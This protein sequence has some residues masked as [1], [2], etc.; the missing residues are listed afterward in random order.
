M[1]YSWYEIHNHLSRT[2]AS[3][4]F[5]R[6]FTDLRR[7]SHGVLERY[8]DPADVLSALHGGAI[9]PEEKNQLLVVLVEAAQSEVSAHARSGL[10]LTLLALWP[11]LDAVL[12]RLRARRLGD[13]EE[14]ASEVLARATEAIHSLDFG[15]VNRIAGTIVRNVERDII[16]AHRRETE[17]ASQ[18]VELNPDAVA[19]C[20]MMSV[21]QQHEGLLY[22]DLRRLIGCDADLVMRIA[23]GGSSQSEAAAELGHSEA[24]ARKRWQRAKMK[25]CADLQRCA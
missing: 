4:R 22:R 1:S 21:R 18:C 3:L 23:V 8:H 13:R 11:G 5:H 12:G 7:A 2:C 15:R 9:S 25:L 10:T 6:G 19:T 14:L 24:A 16:R 20:G 17:E